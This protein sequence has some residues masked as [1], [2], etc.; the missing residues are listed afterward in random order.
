MLAPSPALRGQPQRDELACRK[1]LP[2]RTPTITVGIV[3]DEVLIRTGVRDVL[4]R[5]STMSPVKI[6]VVGEAANGAGAVEL[7]SRRRPQVLLVDATLPDLDVVTVTRQ[8]L[9][10]APESR[11]VVLAVR[12]SEKLLFPALRAGAVG[13]LP[14]NSEPGELVKAVRTVAL[15]GAVLSPV[16]ARHLVSYIASVDTDRLDT[17]RDLVNSLTDREQEVLVYVAKGMA[18]ATI[19]R[20]MYLSVGAIKAHVSRLLTKLDCENRVQA[21]LLAVQAG[22]LDPAQAADQQA[23]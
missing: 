20:R 12:G 11:I 10:F 14:K 3:D 21:A 9:R 5:A 15:G 17:A 7:V 13:F 6:A 16:A 8:V 2:D 23:A 22:M 19:A 4:N 1:I 18:N